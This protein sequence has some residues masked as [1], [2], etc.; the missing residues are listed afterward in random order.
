MEKGRDEERSVIKRES[1]QQIIGER[2]NGVDRSDL[3]DLDKSCKC[4][5]QKEKIKSIEESK[6]GSHK[7]AGRKEKVPN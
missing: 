1:K 5:C 7:K 6:K 2:P 4:A 3:C